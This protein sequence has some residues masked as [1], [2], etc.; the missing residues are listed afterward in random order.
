[1]K[2]PLHGIRVVDLTRVLSGPFATQQLIDLGADVVKIEHPRVGDDTRRFGP[3]FIE[4]ESTYFMSVNRGKKSVAIDLKNERGRDLVL[5]LI[6]RVDVVLENFK[7]GTAERL[8]LGHAELRKEKPRLVTC[9]I[10][11]Y[12]TDGDP[13]YEGR[14]GYDAVIQ[15]ASGLMAL[16]G[17]PHGPPTKVGVAIAD[18]VAGLYAAQGILAALV[19]RGSTGHGSHVEVSMLDAT[20]SLLTYQAGI[21]FATHQSPKRMGNAHPSICPYETIDTKDGLYALAVGNDEQFARLVHV[22]DLPWLEKDERFTTNAARV[23]HREALIAVLRP[24]FL[25]K[26]MGEWDALLHEE[27]IPGGPVLTVPRAIEH[28][29]MRARG[30]VLEHDHPKAGRIRTIA[31]PIR[32]DGWPPLDVSPPPLLGEH[33]RQVLASE[34]GLTNEEIDALVEAR[35]VAEP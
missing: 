11:G 31:S 34:L 14:A 1:V 33:T 5:G 29:Q 16:T 2:A 3:P 23:E 26:T 19:E 9:S 12:G 18:M 30:S 13:D 20:C 24:R 7:P 4:G 10:N 6:Q 27:G 32:M 15:A 8:G 17:D 21:Y 28:P 35:I 22:M 25:E